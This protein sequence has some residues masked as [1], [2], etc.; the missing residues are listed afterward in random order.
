MNYLHSIMHRKY[1]EEAKYCRSL[2]IYLFIFIILFSSCNVLDPYLRQGNLLKKGKYDLLAYKLNRISIKS[3][4]SISEAYIKALHFSSPNSPFYSPDSSYSWSLKGKDYWTNAEKWKKKTVSRR[5]NKTGNPFDY[6]IRK[7][8]SLAFELALSHNT[9]KSFNHYIRYY[10]PAVFLERAIHKRDSLAFESAKNENTYL[11]YKGFLDKYPNSKEA[12]EA[13]EIYELLLYETH[14]RDK[15]LASFENFIR[16]FPNSP[17]CNEALKYVYQYYT[18]DNQPSSFERYLK[19]YPN[20]PKAPEAKLWIESFKEE[21]DSTPT[22]LWP[23]DKTEKFSIYNLKS[24]LSTLL[25]DSLIE[26]NYVSSN[27]KNDFIYRN[28]GK[29][30]LLD[31]KGLGLI[32]SVFSHLTYASNNVLIYGI[33]ENYGLI[34][35]SGFRITSPLYQNISPLN[36][37][38][39]VAQ[40]G[41]KKVLLAHNGLNLYEGEFDSLT[42]VLPNILSIRRK[43]NYELFKSKDFLN[44]PEKPNPG[45]TCESLERFKKFMIVKNDGLYHLLDHNFRIMQS[46]FSNYLKNDDYLLLS[47]ADSCFIIDSNGIMLNGQAMD[48]VKANFAGF[49]IFHKEQISCFAFDSLYRDIE[50]IKEFKP[51]YLHFTLVDSTEFLLTDNAKI[52]ITGYNSFS[53]L[54]NPKQADYNAFLVREEKELGIISTTGEKL[55]QGEYEEILVYNDSTFRIKK[56]GLYYL[57]DRSGK[58]LIKQGFDAIDLSQN[59]GILLFHNSRFGMYIPENDHFIKPQFSRPIKLIDVNKKLLTISREKGFSQVYDAEEK[60]YLEI[61]GE[62][63]EMINDSLVFVKSNFQWKLYNIYLEEEHKPQISCD[64][65]ELIDDG[66]G[67]TDIKFLKSGSYGYLNT[68]INT[69]IYPEYYE[70]FEIRNSKNEI[71]NFLSLKYYEE[72]EFYLVQL[73]DESFNEV[74]KSTVPSIQLEKSFGL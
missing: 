64:S 70:M 67:N 61:Q 41:N 12:E 59:S 35:N 33:D 2:P 69:Y 63:F 10:E 6:L 66:K 8:D 9:E 13:K 55:F 39:N 50:H 51:L 36:D 74:K 24:G 32:P 23:V 29:F 34:H 18:L 31:N 7:S 42:E 30:G 16:D 54:S 68:E 19:K 52:D 45:Y 37:T 47:K 38:F 44:P 56:D 58:K 22:F 11:S 25:F 5:L 20:S 17:Y 1:K 57:I 43:D 60:K 72:I 40:I 27:F 26:A 15:Q 62:V 14:V 48:S 46:G 65:Y 73:F 21:I 49:T 3:D 28:E 53:L 71:S 4:S